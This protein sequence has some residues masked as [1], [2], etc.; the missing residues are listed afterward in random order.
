MAIESATNI[1]PRPGGQRAP[2]RPR[3]RDQRLP[4]YSGPRDQR[5][6]VEAEPQ[7]GSRSGGG[8]GSPSPPVA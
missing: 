5:P 4:I 1:M 6:P 3:E 7:R 8:R 2:L